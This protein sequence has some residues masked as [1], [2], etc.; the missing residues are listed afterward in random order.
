MS[1]EG[2][3]RTTGPN[4]N[5]EAPGVGAHC[6]GTGQMKRTILREADATG[7]EVVRVSD[8]QTGY[9]ETFVN[10]MGRTYTQAEYDAYK[11]MT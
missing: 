6:Q 4:I 8:P 11:A 2:E 3:K 9:A 5:N 10:T 1:L 7:P